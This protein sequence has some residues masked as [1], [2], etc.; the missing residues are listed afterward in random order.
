MTETKVRHKIIINADAERDFNKIYVFE[1]DEP[2]IITQKEG[3]R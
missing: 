1:D 3:E 2:E